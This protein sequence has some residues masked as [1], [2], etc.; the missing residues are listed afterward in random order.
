LIIQID[1]LNENAD[2][3]LTVD[4]SPSKIIKSLQHVETRNDNQSSYSAWI[5]NDKIFTFNTNEMSILKNPFGDIEDNFVIPNFNKAFLWVFP[6]IEDSYEVSK[7][8]RITYIVTHNMTMSIVN[9]NS[10]ISESVHDRVNTLIEAD[11]NAEIIINKKS[12]QEGLSRIL[13]GK[14]ELA[15]TEVVSITILDDAFICFWIDNQ[16]RIVEI[17]DITG[18][19]DQCVPFAVNLQILYSLLKTH[20][21]ENITIKITENAIIILSE[22]GYIGIQP[23]VNTIVCPEEMQEEIEELGFDENLDVIF[24]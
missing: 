1:G 19:D 6:L 13:A 24:K 23:K 3:V 17:I 7:T 4:G 15:N 16:S 12:L 14:S 21:T 18:A 10:E 8:E 22:N 5:S 20:E 9:M 11:S 2:L